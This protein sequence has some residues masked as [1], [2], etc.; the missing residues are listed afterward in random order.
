L[1]IGS[2]DV[3][4]LFKIFNILG[5][6]CEKDWPANS[7]IPLDSFNNNKNLK[8]INMTEN[9][10]KLIPNMDEHA[11]DLLKKL[12][13]FNTQYRITAKDALDHV[14]FKTS[15]VEDNKHGSASCDGYLAANDNTEN[16]QENEKPLLSL[17][18]ITNIF[19]PNILKRKR[20]KN[21]EGKRA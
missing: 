14:Y 7:V 15:F 9:L 18:D 21:Q 2:S 20:F 3:D 13:D 12:L 1:F 17:P 16:D 11:L 6:P 19:Q 4:Q 5:L 8:K 10:R